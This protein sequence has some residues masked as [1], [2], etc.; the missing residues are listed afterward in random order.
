[1]KVLSDLVKMK[2]LIQ[3]GGRFKPHQRLNVNQGPLPFVT[4]A[5]R[6][7]EYVEPVAKDNNTWIS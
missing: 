5:K 1:M 6:T 7:Y 3:N 4:D 2:L